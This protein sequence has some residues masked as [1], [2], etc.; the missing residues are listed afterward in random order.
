MCKSAK[1][2]AEVV[3]ADFDEERGLVK[4][5]ELVEK[6]VVA[7]D[8]GPA[9]PATEKISTP[10]PLNMPGAKKAD[11]D[12]AA[13]YA[14]TVKTTG[15]DALEAATPS[16][17]FV[18]V[19]A[20]DGGDLLAG[21]IQAAMPDVVVKK[22]YRTR[23]GQ[24]S[25]K[26]AEAEFDREAAIE[27]VKATGD[28]LG[29]DETG[30]VSGAEQAIQTVA[31]LIIS[32]AQALADMPA[33]DCDI[34]L[35]M[36]AVHALRLFSNRE[37][38]EQGAIDPDSVV[39]LSAEP[40]TTKKSKYNADQ[41]AQMLKAGQ[42]M[43]N[44][45]GDPS[46]PIKDEEDLKNAIKAVGRGKGSHAAIKNHIV[47][48]AKA[49]GKVDMLPDDWNADGSNDADKSVEPD[50][51]DSGRTVTLEIDG[52]QVTAR[53]V[54]TDTPKAAKPA[55]EHDADTCAADDCEMCADATKAA[56]PEEPV[57]ADKT[58]QPDLVKALTGALKDEKSELR[59]MFKSL[60]DTTSTVEALTTIGARLDKVEQMATPGGPAL[61]RTDAEVKKSRSTD[62]E[63]QA[64][65]FRRQAEAAEDVDLRRGYLSK[66]TSLANEAR[67]LAS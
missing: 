1:A 11:V 19:V 51:T 62:L 43:P 34:D 61:R 48:R 6:T 32:E 28:G 14:E 47:K 35:L 8:D 57:D 24:F 30:D 42:A 21:A 13:D 40:D 54:E 60:F 63:I 55:V 4:C 50:T 10:S 56:T 3:A 27:L 45:D 9:E 37:K 67:A 18:E 33:Q 5:E 66:A 64:E 16:Q 25:E 44:A 38:L 29:Q 15:A 49:L 23:Q 20:N 58:T 41:M 26:A 31:Q 12:P 39:M 46:Y 65:H 2:G 53:L 17:V 36:S 7:D 59:E 22:V 52:K